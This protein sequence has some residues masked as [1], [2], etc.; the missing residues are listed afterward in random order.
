MKQYKVTKYNP[1]NRN[2]KG[3]YMLDEW[4]DFSDVGKQF[5]GIELTMEEYLKV[6]SA[7]TIVAI[8]ILKKCDINSLTVKKLEKCFRKQKIQENEK[9]PTEDVKI[10]L[11]C[12]NVNRTVAFERRS[13]TIVNVVQV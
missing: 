5:N 2:E 9:I 13:A 6:E 3:Y 8:S 7:Y 11:K 4:T 12:S 1:A 10:V